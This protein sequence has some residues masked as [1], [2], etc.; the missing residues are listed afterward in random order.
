MPGSEKGFASGCGSQK[1]SRTERL[2]PGAVFGFGGFA[3]VWK[4]AS[5]TGVPCAIMASLRPV[6]ESSQELQKELD[7]LQMPKQLAGHPHVVSLIEVEPLG[8]YLVSRWGHRRKH[9]QAH[10]WGDRRGQ[11]RD[12]LGAIG[13]FSE[14]AQ[15]AWQEAQKRKSQ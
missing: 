1:L 3:Q 2:Y 14:G 12:H 5:P 11:L 4:A 10:R 6:D 7:A 9:R 13:G 15:A 8:G